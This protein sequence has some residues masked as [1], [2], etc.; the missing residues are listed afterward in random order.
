MLASFEESCLSCF[1]MALQPSVGKDCLRCVVTVG[2]WGFSFPTGGARLLSS[3][4]EEP[5]F[6]GSR[7][8]WSAKVLPGAHPPGPCFLLQEHGKAALGGRCK[9]TNQLPLPGGGGWGVG[10]D[11]FVL[12]SSSTSNF[13]ALPLLGSRGGKKERKNTWF[14]CLRQWMSDN[15]WVSSETAL[16]TALVHDWESDTVIPSTTDAHGT[17]SIT[18][19]SRKTAQTTCASCSFVHSLTHLA[20]NLLRAMGSGTVPGIS[21]M[22]V[23]KRAPNPCPWEAYILMEPTFYILY[24]FMTVKLQRHFP[25]V[26]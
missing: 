10:F 18:Q 15:R 20:N 14:E 23:N 9:Q 21:V 3:L 2:V 7:V 16:I 19:L 17:W 11:P 24:I 25:N 6:L 13:T 1:L 26:L 22:A 8:D 4:S 12:L 5:L